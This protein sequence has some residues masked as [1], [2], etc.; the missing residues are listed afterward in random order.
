VKATA[1]DGSCTAPFLEALRKHFGPD[2]ELPTSMVIRNGKA[3][4]VL[5]PPEVR[6]REGR[7][8]TRTSLFLPFCGICGKP[9]AV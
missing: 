1:C 9:S 8:W 3:M 7:R 4:T 6:K 2:A 5:T